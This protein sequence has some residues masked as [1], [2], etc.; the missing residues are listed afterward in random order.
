MEIVFNITEELVKNF[1]EITGDKNSLHMDE[2]IARKFRYRR[3]IVHGMLP[4]SFIFFLQQNFPNNPICFIEITAK[5][6][7][8]VF[9]GY[10]I[11]LSLEYHE[12]KDERFNFTATWYD[13]NKTE[14]IRSSGKFSL[15]SEK[16]KRTFNELQAHQDCFITNPLSENRLT[17][18]EITDKSESFNFVIGKELTVAYIKKLVQAVK[19]GSSCEFFYEINPNLITTLLMST[20]VGMRL[21]GRY[22]TFLDFK[23][24]YQKMIEYSKD[25]TMKGVVKKVFP[26]SGKIRLN[27]AIN[28][29]SE[30][31]AKAAANVLINPL[32]RKTISCKEILSDYFDLGVKGRVVLIT[33]AS[34]GIGAATAKL[35]A[36]HG[37]KVVVNY[38]KGKRDAEL[39]VEDICSAKGEAI[40]LQCDIREEEQVRM[41]VLKII[42]HFGTIDILVNNAVKD[43]ISKDIL[44]LEWGDYLD[45]L[46][47]SLKGMHN[48]CREVIPILKEKK[49]GKIIGLSS[50]FVDS[51]I[52]D[53]N[54]YITVKS[55]IVGYIRSLAKDLIRYNIQA[56]LVVPNITETDLLS[57]ISPDFIKKL[58]E[59]SECG[60]NLS[61]IEVAQTIIF[62][63]SKWADTITGQKIVLNLGETPFL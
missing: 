42:D 6:K 2:E 34:R 33:G 11:L 44:K 22:A 50:I 32:P 21:P 14:L 49:Q 63:T 47:V 61:P 46:E 41:M 43:F 54:K 48:C 24:S 40:A 60:R 36:M 15:L 20:L 59:E 55:A 56:N 25:Y 52:K 38:N 4:F 30:E 17:I 16:R 35:F 37:A 8:P 10:E 18:K 31:F 39:V 45:E 3:P 57:S 12:E 23:V 26:A 29:N 27:V 28:S 7:A 19:Q 53:Q 51:P 1:S 58:H 5:F 13:N 9:I 62:L